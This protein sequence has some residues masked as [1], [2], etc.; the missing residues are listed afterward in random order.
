MMR[1]DRFLTSGIG[2]LLSPPKKRCQN[3]SLHSRLTMPQV[4]PVKYLVWLLQRHRWRLLLAL[5]QLIISMIV[6]QL[7]DY[8]SKTWRLN[9]DFILY[10][11]KLVLIYS[12]ISASWINLLIFNSHPLP[13][14]WKKIGLRSLEDCKYLLICC[15]LF[16]WEEKIWQ[17]IRYGSINLPSSKIAC[18][19]KYNDSSFLPFNMADNARTIK[20]FVV[21][22]NLQSF[23]NSDIKFSTEV[24]HFFLSEDWLFIK[25]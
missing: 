16:S 22:K 20:A 19:E 2:L 1:L 7:Q 13:I 9:N 21:P 6:A 4:Y 3:Y 10:G 12:E 5:L 11:G 25:A 15:W 17:I 24:A 23:N 14:L 8:L 18:F